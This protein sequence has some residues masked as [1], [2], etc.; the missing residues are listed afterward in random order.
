MQHL[1]LW[2]INQVPPEVCDQA[3]QDFSNIEPMQATMGSNGEVVNNAHRNT[4]VRFVEP[5]HWMHSL[6]SMV[7]AE[8]NETCKWGYETTASERIQF[9]EYGP[10]QHYQWHVDNFPLSG[11]PTDRKITVVC[12]L[13]EPEEF[14]GGEFQVRLYSEYTAP[15]KKGSIIAFPSILEHQVTPV[16]SGVRYSATMWLN[17]PRFR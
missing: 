7:A 17:G 4:T 6:F 12:L 11:N 10:S 16:L 9:A 1:P 3:L 2:H 13:N 5:T 15:L 14:E 8:A